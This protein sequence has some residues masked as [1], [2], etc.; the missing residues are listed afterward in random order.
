MCWKSPT[1]WMCN[2]NWHLWPHCSHKSMERTN[3]AN[4]SWCFASLTL[5]W[6]WDDLDMTFRA[7]GVATLWSAA[8]THVTTCTLFEIYQVLWTVPVLI[9]ISNFSPF[10]C[11]VLGIAKPSDIWTNPW[12]NTP[13]SPILPPKSLYMCAE[14]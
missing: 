7:L 13:Q 5:L 2:T 8:L 10:L 1:Q 12:G 6:P 14:S 9:Q 11:A 4:Y 3:C